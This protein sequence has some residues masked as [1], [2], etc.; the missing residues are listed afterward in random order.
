LIESSNVKEVCPPPPLHQ[1]ASIGAATHFPPANEISSPIFPSPDLTNHIQT[2][3]FG[4]ERRHVT[5]VVT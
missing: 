5:R 3:S 4:E 2:T 1:R